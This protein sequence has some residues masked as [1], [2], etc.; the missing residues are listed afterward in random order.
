MKTAV[1][2]HANGIIEKK[3]FVGVPVTRRFSYKKDERGSIIGR[4]YFQINPDQNLQ[5]PV[6]NYSEIKEPARQ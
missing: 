4:I 1:F 5:A 6:I 2:C 3:L